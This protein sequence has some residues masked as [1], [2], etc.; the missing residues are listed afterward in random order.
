[1]YRTAGRAV[2]TAEEVEER[3]FSGAGFAD[4]GEHLAAVDVEVETVENQEIVGTGAVFFGEVASADVGLWHLLEYDNAIP[5]L[6]ALEQRGGLVWLM[7]KKWK[8][9]RAIRRSFPIFKRF[10]K[11]RANT[12][13]RAR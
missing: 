9:K 8:T 12:W 1:M 6:C 13:T 7:M 3:G 11:G 2:Q 4:E 10:V 5:D